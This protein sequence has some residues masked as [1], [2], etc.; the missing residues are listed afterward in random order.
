MKYLTLLFF[1]FCFYTLS[2]Q[3]GPQVLEILDPRMEIL[4]SK[5]AKME[6]LAEGFGWAEGPVWI[7]ELNGILFSDVPN[8]K[9]YLWT[10]KKGLSLFLYPSGMT[11][12]APNNK[13]AG[14]N[15]LGLDSDGN[16]ILCQHGDRSISRLNNWFFEEPK[17]DVLVDHFNGKWLNSPNDLVFDKQ[18]SI[19]FTDPPYGLRNGDED[20]LKE[21]NFNGVFKWSARE[22]VKLVEKNMSRPNGIAL[23]LDEKTAYVANSDPANDVIMA[24]D[25]LEDG[26]LN[27]RIFFDGNIL[28]QTREGLFDGLKMHSSGIIFATGPGGVLLL[29]SMGVHLGTI[30]PGK[31]TANCS[32][33]K[34]EQY[35]YLTST[36]VLA[37]VKL[38]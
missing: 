21:L 29:D 38:N 5:N 14:S 35:L 26:F 12:H 8:N 34:D 7:P 37:R 6:I 9:A 1:S 17:Y 19:Y 11:N 27:G 18:G 36:D 33:D 2:A 24:F 16:L 25:V 32:F 28:S 10:E 13:S 15:G 20:D 4:I 3:D 30:M 31:K 23:S 22:E